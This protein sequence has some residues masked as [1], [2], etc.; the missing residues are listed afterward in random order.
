MRLLSTSIMPDEPRSTLLLA[1]CLLAYSARLWFVVAFAGQTLFLA[2]IVLFYGRAGVVGDWPRWNLI[3]SPGI[4]TG[5]A[6]GNSVLGAH[7]LAAACVTLC[8]PLQLLPAVRARA[9]AFHRWN[10]RVYLLTAVV[11]S[12]S[13]LYLVWIRGGHVGGLVQYLGIT[14]QAIIILACAVFSLR[15]AL[16]RDFR[17]H[18]RWALRLYLAVSGVWFM[19]I[20]LF[21][22]V[23]VNHGPVGFDPETFRGPFLDTWSFGRYL[24]PLA[25]L[26]GYF[27]TQDH[28]GATGRLLMTAGL[29]AATIATSLGIVVS[30]LFLWSQG[31]AV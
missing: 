6:L 1:D 10:G 18:R 15:A 20:G 27:R 4:V 3:L 9:P 31:L 24:L 26:E 21:F 17:R 16:Q 30:T 2:H 14:G 19:A 12:L 5:D 7:L 22:W 29:G 25:V 23:F 8:G 13:A 28:A 11:A